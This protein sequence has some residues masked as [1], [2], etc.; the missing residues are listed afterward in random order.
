MTGRWLKTFRHTSHSPARRNFLRYFG[1]SAIATVTMGY[2]FPPSSEGRDL[3]LE[4]L[5]S[6]FPYNSRCQDYLPGVQARTESGELIET[7][8]LLATTKPGD[9]V[10]AEGLPRVSP[11]Y[12][13]I[14][15]GPSVAEYA[16]GS[17]CTHLGCTVKWKLEQNRFVCPCH[18][19][20]YDALGRVVKGPAKRS[21]AL[22]TVVEKQNQVRL[23]DHKPGVD[24]R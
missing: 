2:L 1:I 14:Q 9:R 11:V 21:L 7:K 20:Q 15:E 6:S 19:S 24:P 12:L 23:V 3:D 16:I 22:V 10:P 18:G 17:V 8:A 13:V 4:T 5:C